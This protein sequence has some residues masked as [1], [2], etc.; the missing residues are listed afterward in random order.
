MTP[1]ETVRSVQCFLIR[2]VS[3]LPI[4]RIRSS[5]QINRSSVCLLLC[6]GKR[7]TGSQDSQRAGH[8]SQLIRVKL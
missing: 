4:V 1:S 8:V 2:S 5:L 3:S 6:P 7:T